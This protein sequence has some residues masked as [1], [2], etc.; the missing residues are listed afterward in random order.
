MVA[1]S[2][3]C[4]TGTSCGQGQVQ[5][6]AQPGQQC[7]GGEDLEPC[8]RDF[9]GEG[10]P[11]QVGTDR[12]DVVRVLWGRHEVG[13]HLW[14]RYTDSSTAGEDCAAAG[15]LSG[16]RLA[17]APDP[18]SAGRWSG[19]R[20]VATSVKAEPPPRGLRPPAPPR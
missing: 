7:V 9:D 8:G 19:R 3:L 4:R 13:A 5:P 18:C 11:V 15:L 12:D 10:Q 14:P 20:E 6:L 1:R 2:V 17:V 16:G